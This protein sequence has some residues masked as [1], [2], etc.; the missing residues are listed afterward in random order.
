[1][2]ELKLTKLEFT[3][4]LKRGHGRAFQYIKQHGLSEVSDIVLE[5][6]LENPA[7]DRQ[8]EGSRA[9][10]LFGMFQGSGEYARFSAAILS[11]LSSFPSDAD[12]Y[13]L[14]HLCE[15]AALMA[16]AGDLSAAA[17]LRSRVLMQNL[18]WSNCSYGCQPLVALDGIPAVI[19]L[20]R[21]FGQLLIEEPDV[22]PPSVDYLTDNLG[23]CDIAKK[24][25]QRLAKTDED[26]KRYLDNEAGYAIHEL[27]AQKKS[28]EERQQEIRE[29]T[30]KDLTLDGILND[31][32]REI[33]K[34]SARYL[35]FGRYATDDELKTVLRCLVEETQQ[36]ACLRLLWVFRRRPLPDL[37]PK[38]WQLAEAKNDAL[39][40][41]ALEAL[42]QSRDPRVGELG[43][44]R[45]RSGNFSEKDSDTL[46]LFIR[47]YQPLDEQLIMAALK[48]LTP[49]EDEV[50]ISIQ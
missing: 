23:I 24:K 31:A 4:A 25:L 35:R 29:R 22:R 50:S 46:D 39:R 41:A 30:R 5:S 21:H 13:D 26:I 40:Y 10:W 16:K 38:V 11:S 37:H 15:L 3:A 49:D 28:P 14:E 27:E 34:H 9:D 19:A 45:L 32:S 6:C 42:A 12:G 36:S 20:A 1:M 2:P 18:D 17:A 44:A 47:N 7:Y 48:L 8:S 43:R 33:G